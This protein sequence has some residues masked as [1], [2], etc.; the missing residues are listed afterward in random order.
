MTP[1]LT[2]SKWF[3]FQLEMI[4]LE[5]DVNEECTENNKAGLKAFCIYALHMLCYCADTQHI[6]AAAALSCASL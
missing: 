5:N 4:Y 6:P 3:I 1:L 2:P